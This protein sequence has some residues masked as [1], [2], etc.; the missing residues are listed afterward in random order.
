MP[1]LITSGLSGVTATDIAEGSLNEKDEK[2]LVTF[3]DVILVIYSSCKTH[4][5]H[6]GLFRLPFRIRPNKL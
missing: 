5:R 2:T 4:I 6:R 1:R 3:Y